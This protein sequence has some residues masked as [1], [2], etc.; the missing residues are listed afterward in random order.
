MTKKELIEKSGIKLRMIDYCV[1]LYLTKGID[2]THKKNRVHFTESGVQK[3]MSRPKARKK[4]KTML[5]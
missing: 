1:S 4:A 5:D 3:I 2:Y